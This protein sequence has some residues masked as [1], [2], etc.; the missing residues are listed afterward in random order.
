[1]RFRRLIF[2]RRYSF[3]IDFLKISLLFFNKKVDIHIYLYLISEVFKILQKRR[4]N[5]FLV[6]LQHLF[7]FFFKKNKLFKGVKLVLKG[8]LKGKTRSS[9]YILNLG[10]APLQTISQNIHYSKI[11]IFTIYGVFGMKFWI[12]WK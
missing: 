4:H 5:Q 8:R 12:N 9:K 10:S 11:H 2:P 1:M 6:F 3:F 7:N